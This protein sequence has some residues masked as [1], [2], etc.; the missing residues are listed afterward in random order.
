[1]TKPLS[2]NHSAQKQ[3]CNYYTVELEIKVYIL[4]YCK[5][6]QCLENKVALYCSGCGD[7]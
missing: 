6:F 4:G 5:I 7:N 2:Q 1:M 3:A